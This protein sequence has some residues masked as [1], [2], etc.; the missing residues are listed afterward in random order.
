[1]NLELHIILVLDLGRFG[2]HPLGCEQKVFVSLVF[3]GVA[4]DPR[5]WRLYWFQIFFDLAFFPT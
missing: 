2:I 1:V 3:Q 4:Q 5:H